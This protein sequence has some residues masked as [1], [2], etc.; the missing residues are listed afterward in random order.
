MN[1]VE[2]LFGHCEMFFPGEGG[3]DEIDELREFMGEY[4]PF[5]AYCTV[6]DLW[7]DRCGL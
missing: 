4:Y 6:E 7:R 3:P 2:E 1:P 5:G